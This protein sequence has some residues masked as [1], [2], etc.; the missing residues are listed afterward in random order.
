MCF[1]LVCW[2]LGFFSLHTFVL[3]RCTV[4]FSEVFLGVSGIDDGDD[5]STSSTEKIKG[6]LR[7]LIV[8]FRVN[9]A[10]V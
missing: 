8:C 1:D 5:I 4:I 3:S 2:G 10:H 6:W 7:E 9:H